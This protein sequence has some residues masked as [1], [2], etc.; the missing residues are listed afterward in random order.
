MVF[1]IYLAVGSVSAFGV[2]RLAQRQIERLAS[3]YATQYANQQRARIA[4][5]LERE[6][7]LA[8]KL[9]DSPL[10]QAWA[11]NESD[12]KLRGQALAELESYRHLF[13]DHSYFFIVD[14]SKNYYF[15]NAQ[16]E[17]KSNELR[18]VVKPD[19]PTSN[20]YFDTIERVN[21]TLPRR[22]LRR[23]DRKAKEAGETRSGYIAR[24]AIG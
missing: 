15:N 10:L 11:Q 5:K 8:Q 21:I 4:A 2:Y 1:G 6:V 19:D 7:V 18:Y 20:W 22:V 17:F 12:P 9:V 24:M 23:L 16:D 14:Q 13:A 3:G